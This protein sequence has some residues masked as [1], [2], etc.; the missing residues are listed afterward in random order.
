MRDVCSV[1]L[2]G[3]VRNATVESTEFQLVPLEL[4]RIKTSPQCYVA[5]AIEQ[6][7]VR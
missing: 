7:L 2:S 6:L 5:N 3:M 4:V 1:L